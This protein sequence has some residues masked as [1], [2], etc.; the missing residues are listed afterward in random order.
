MDSL[1]ISSLCV[2]SIPYI[3]GIWTVVSPGISGDNGV[4]RISLQYFGNTDYTHDI[5][6]CSRLM[7]CQGILR[8][9]GEF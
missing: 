2:G 8:K 9:Q 6:H 1:W 5:V 7:T 3:G 4:T